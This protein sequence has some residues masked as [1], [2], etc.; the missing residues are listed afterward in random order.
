MEIL[1]NKYFKKYK[2]NLI[3]FD[4]KIEK[5]INNSKEFDFDYL[6]DA[7]SV[8]SS[9]IEWNTLDLNSFMNLRIN[10]SI[11]KDVE[12]IENL[13]KAYNFAQTNDLNEKNLLNIHKISS[14]TILIKSKRW[15]Y[16]DDKVWIFWKNWLVYLAIEADKVW[17]KMSELF[18]DISLLLNTDLT[19]KEIFYYAS[20]IHLVFVHIH[21]FADWN[22][23]TARVLEKWFI[24]QK[25]WKDFWKLRCEEYYK[26]NRE[27]Y[28]NNINLWVN[29]YE[30]NYDNCMDFLLMLPNS[31][32]L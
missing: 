20:F 13:T 30:L 2:K 10:K 8:Y 19:N 27:E 26:E 23:R 24:T 17:W 12:E 21:P 4:K 14:K 22:G 32:K 6:T 18:K 31:L 5:F 9:N 29:Y 1:T 15:V 3:N 25:L 7:S 11:T 28:Y 16:R